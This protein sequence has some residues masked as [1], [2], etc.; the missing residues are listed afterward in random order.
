MRNIDKFVTP[1]EPLVMW[2][3]GF[4]NEECDSVLQLGELAEFK[5]AAVGN[6][7]TNDKVRD[8]K[9]IWIEPSPD[10]FWIFDRM[11]E[12]CGK[13]NFDKFQL[14]LKQFDG[15]QYTK[16]D[17]NAH[18]DWHNDTINMPT[19]GLFRKLSFVLMLT[20][21]SEFEGGELL[22]NIDG[23]AERCHT[24]AFNRGDLAVFYPHIPHK[25][26]PVTKGTRV[27]LVTWALGPK[28]V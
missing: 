8:T 24:V 22:L 6:N 28:L 4:S 12:L 1:I 20:D 17:V 16:Y 13:I 14:D 26:T 7:V 25:V 11:N 21:P 5:R 3:Q 15:F 19:N 2:G 27:T 18:Y 9:I 23:N 10:T